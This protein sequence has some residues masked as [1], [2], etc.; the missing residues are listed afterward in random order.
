MLEWTQIATS[1]TVPWCTYRSNMNL[2]KEKK[3]VEKLTPTHTNKDV[4]PDW[5]PL[6][7][8]T[9]HCM[10]H[11]YSRAHSDM[12]SCDSCL[13]LRNEHVTSSEFEQNAVLIAL[14]PLPLQ[15]AGNGTANVTSEI[16][17]NKN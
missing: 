1:S 13:D 5:V 4:K 2:K 9:P 14:T 3:I 12:Y 10:W 15:A 7:E 17:C 8:I 16:A 6:N 11:D